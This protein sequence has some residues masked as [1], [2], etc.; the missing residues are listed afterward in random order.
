MKKSVKKKLEGDFS[1][2]AYTLGIAS[3]VFAFFTPLAGFILG[4]VG[5]TQSKKQTNSVSRKAKK[6]NMIGIIVSA[7]ILVASIIAAIYFTQ[8]GVL[9][10]FPVN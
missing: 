4:I 5:F 2:V 9:P 3:I 6:L 7:I 10:N 8:S 1:Y